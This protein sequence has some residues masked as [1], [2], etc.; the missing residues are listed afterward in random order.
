MKR[1]GILKLVAAIITLSC[2]L[3]TASALAAD[4]TVSVQGTNSTVA[5]QAEQ[6]EWYYRNNNG[7]MEKR[8]W[9]ITYGVWRTD[10]MPV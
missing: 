1:K 2:I 7:I 9:S 10:W 8:L 3:P 6:T 4:S 5:I